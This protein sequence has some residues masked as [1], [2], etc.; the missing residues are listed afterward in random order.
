[1]AAVMGS[2][3]SYSANGNEWSS[4]KAYSDGIQRRFQLPLT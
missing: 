1:M 2:V 4:T 3:E